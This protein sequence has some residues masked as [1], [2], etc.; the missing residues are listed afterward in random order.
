[1]S[2]TRLFLLATGLL[3]LVLGAAYLVAPVPLGT[4]ADFAART[5]T[6]TIEL[7]GFY[8]GQMIGLG[9]F[10]LL[11]VRWS[12]FESPALLVV[13]ASL[14]GTA[15]GRVVGIAAAG[16]LPPIILGVLTLEALGAAG[17][18]LLWGRAHRGVRS[19]G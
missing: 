15:L 12:A 3:Y 8:G 18:L 4:L 6:A 7:R 9:A 2:L 17:A 19:P 5:P 10:V 14:G 1:M 13:A 11:G 16:S